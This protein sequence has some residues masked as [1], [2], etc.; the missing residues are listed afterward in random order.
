MIILV[1][2]QVPL[3]FV[4]GVLSIARCWFIRALKSPLSVCGFSIL[5][6]PSIHYY[7]LYGPILPGL[8]DYYR[9]C[10][11]ISVLISSVC[12]SD[13]SLRAC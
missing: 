7:L 9:C 4:A 13:A 5:P 10:K 2:L 11:L 3:T 1:L 6:P 12:S 8:G